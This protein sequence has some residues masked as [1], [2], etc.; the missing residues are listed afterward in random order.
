MC[1]RYTL[2]TRGQT[3]ADFFGLSEEPDLEPRYNI[4]PTQQ[5]PVVLG[6]LVG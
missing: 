2:K 4:A 1:G 6:R 3:V 5:I